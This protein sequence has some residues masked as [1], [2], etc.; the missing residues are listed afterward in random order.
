MNNVYLR[1]VEWIDVD[2]LYEWANDK[3]VRNN[4]FNTATIQ[5]NDHKHWFEK[6]MA[7]DNIVMYILC[8][9][10]SNIGQIRLH[11]SEHTAIINYSISQRHRGMGYGK[12]IIHLIENRIVVDKPD[13]RYLKAYIKS[14]N[15]ASQNIF[16]DNGYTGKYDEHE[17]HYVYFKDLSEFQKRVVR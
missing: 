3:Q 15:I 1:P 6:S 8:N 14:N 17:K 7:D 2:L 11:C 4:S 9:K 5:Y 12:I 16:A 13:I 10:E